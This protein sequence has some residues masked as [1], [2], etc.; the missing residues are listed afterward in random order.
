MTLRHRPLKTD[1]VLLERLKQSVEDV[2]K[3]T[4]EEREK[5]HKA[6]RESWVRANK[7]WND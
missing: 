7:D 6:Q 3:M 4:P 5:L 1:P 2:K